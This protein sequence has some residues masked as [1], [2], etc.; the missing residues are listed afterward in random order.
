MRQVEVPVTAVNNRVV[1]ADVDWEWRCQPTRVIPKVDAH[2]FV[3][4]YDI[5]CTTCKHRAFIT[6]PGLRGSRIP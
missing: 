4:G 5:E 1:M 6:T 2:G 3:V